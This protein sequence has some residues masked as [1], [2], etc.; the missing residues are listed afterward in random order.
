MSEINAIN[1]AIT[2]TE[3]LRHACRWR[4]RSY[5]V[6]GGADP[7]LPLIFENY[8]LF[9]AQSPDTGRGVHARSRL[10]SGLGLVTLT[11]EIFDVLP[12]R[13]P[14]THDAARS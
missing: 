6:L 7:R 11:L 13:F 5:W 8:D 4:L 3:I 14:S 2:K 9:H 10:G 1:L 12:G